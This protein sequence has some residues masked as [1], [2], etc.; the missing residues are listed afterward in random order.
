MAGEIVRAHIFIEGRVQGVFYRA[1]TRDEAE[2]LGFTGWVKN[3]VDGRVEAVFEGP[4]EKV[5]EM[6][7]KCREGSRVA[8]VEHLD[9]IWEDATGEFEGFEIRY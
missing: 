8:K 9:V 7:K 3:L 4:K 2:K 5:K 6:V 1:W